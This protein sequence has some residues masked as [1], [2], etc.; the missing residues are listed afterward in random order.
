MLWIILKYPESEKE[1][2]NRKSFCYYSP[3]SISRLIEVTA[4][5]IDGGIKRLKRS[6]LLW[7]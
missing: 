4:Q 3:A 5:E 2:L 6:I 7:M 1:I